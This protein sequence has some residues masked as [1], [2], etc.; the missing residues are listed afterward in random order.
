ME[1]QQKEPRGWD[2][3]LLVWL[4]TSLQSRNSCRKVLC[5]T[6]L[7]HSMSERI[8]RS[9]LLSLNDFNISTQSPLLY[10]FYDRV[11][12]LTLQKKSLLWESYTQWK[13]GS[14]RTC[15]VV[16]NGYT[17]TNNISIQVIVHLGESTFLLV[18][19]ESRIANYNA[20]VASDFWAWKGNTAQ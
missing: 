13:W 1:P 7:S 14:R 10:K 17:V 16:T 11:F 9:Q 12:N 15:V 5:F 19:S 6:S 2:D 4:N 20:T 18:G 3:S 8:M